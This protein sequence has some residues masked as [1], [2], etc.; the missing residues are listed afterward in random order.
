MRPDL[1]PATGAVIDGGLPGA[2]AGLLDLEVEDMDEAMAW[3]TKLG[4]PRPPLSLSRLS[5]CEHGRPKSG[6]STPLPTDA[7]VH[8]PL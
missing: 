5:A 2:I 8:A 6:R 4:A 1:T 7:I 3:R